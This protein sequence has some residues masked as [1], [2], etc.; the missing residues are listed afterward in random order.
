MTTRFTNFLVFLY[1]WECVRDRKGNVIS[2]NVAGDPGGL[3]KYGIDRAS[4]KDTD[5]EHLTE[6]QAREIYWQ[7][8]TATGS[9]S[10]ADKLGE[11]YFNA[12]VNCGGSRA[13]KLL[14][15]SRNAAGF[16]DNQEAF[17]RALAAKRADLRQFL[18]GWL[19]RTGDLR[20]FVGV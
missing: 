5:I 7:E 1:R 4:H 6:P 19:N 12:C 14:A 3:T 15:T 18:K 20:K 11:C 17:Y 2:E 13:R 10:V 8:W 9:E 16:I